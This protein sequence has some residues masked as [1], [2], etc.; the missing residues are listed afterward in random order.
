[1][2]SAVAIENAWADDAESNDCGICFLSLNCKASPTFQCDAGHVICLACRDML[3]L[4]AGRCH[5]CCGKVA[6]RGSRRDYGRDLWPDYYSPEIRSRA[7]RGR[8]R[9]PDV[10]CGLVGTT[11]ELLCHF[12]RSHKWPI[13]NGVTSGDTITV[14]LQDGIN[15]VAVDCS[16]ASSDDNCRDIAG[17]YLIVLHVG[18]ETFG[19]TVV[20]VCV[21]PRGAATDGPSFWPG[22]DSRCHLSLSYSRNV[23]AADDDDT[24]VQRYYQTTDFSVACT[25]LARGLPDPDTWFEAQVLRSD[26]LEDNEETIEV[27]L[28]TIIH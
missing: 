13:T 27:N 11:A 17:R 6:C 26:D 3:A 23:H 16:G 7:R 1:M 19:R 8:C 28:R 22:R 4:P 2:R 10:A 5:I 20:G 24:L 12:V 25:D 18:R 15:I 9:C 21:R 14:R